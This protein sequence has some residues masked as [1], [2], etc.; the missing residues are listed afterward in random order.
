[1][2]GSMYSG[3]S[4]LK[5]NASAM[6]VIG[7]NIANVDTTGFKASRVAFANVFSASLATHSPQTGQGTSLQSVQAQWETGSLENTGSATDFAISGTGLFMV[8]DSSNGMNYYTRA[9][10]FEWNRDGNLVN[11]DGFI[12][13]GYEIDTVDGTVGRVGDISLPLATTTPQETSEISLGLNLNSDAEVGDT[14][15]SSITV[16]NSLGSEVVLDVLFTRTAT[17]WDWH[18]ETD[19]S[20]A[21][22]TT[23]PYCTAGGYIQ[24]LSTPAEDTGTLDVDNSYWG[25]GAWSDPDGDGIYD[26]YTFDAASAVTMNSGAA[27]GGN[28]IINITSLNGADDMAVEWVLGD[29]DF[30]GSN[31]ASNGT[32]TGYASDSAKTSQNQNGYP[33]G[34][35]QSISVDED[36]VFSG[37]YSNGEITPFAQLALA[38]FPSY[39]GLAKMGSNLYSETMRS[40]EALIGVA[41]TGGLGSIAPS[42]LELSNVDLATEFVEMITTQRAYQ[43]NSRVITTSDELLQELIN[44]KR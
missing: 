35:L 15:T 43:A 29:G 7:D 14:F 18:V 37:I 23:P 16:F 22:P 44:I 39:S 24:F 13:Q 40:G 1:M 9:G 41:N 33:A 42:S 2:I 11:S 8:N 12:V 25:T 10:Q 5:V 31:F 28:P 32:V 34:T 27:T 30:A 6:E 17:G 4:G 20:S 38:N 26:T 36:G 19:P 3:I 21:D